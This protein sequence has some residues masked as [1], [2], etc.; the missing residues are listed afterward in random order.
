MKAN[1]K[2]SRSPTNW[3][4][5]LVPLGFDG[6]RGLAL[7]EFADDGHPFA[8][9]LFVCDFFDRADGLI[10]DHGFAH[11]RQRQVFELADTFASDVKFLADFF[12]G[13][14]VAT[15]ETKAELDDF[16]LSFVE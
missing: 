16:G 5:Q 9:A 11:F 8:L 3:R 13:K 1:D 14:F 10:L 12:E 15:V 2:L 7:Y 6:F 4:Q